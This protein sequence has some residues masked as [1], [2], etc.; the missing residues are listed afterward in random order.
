MGLKCQVCLSVPIFHYSWCNVQMYCYRLYWQ[1]TDG[2]FTLCSHFKVKILTGVVWYCSSPHTSW[3]LWCYN[4]H[5]ICSRTFG[6]GNHS[7][8]TSG[9]YHRTL[10]SDMFY[11]PENDRKKKAYMYFFSSDAFFFKVQGHSNCFRYS[12]NYVLLRER[13]LKPPPVA[14]LQWGRWSQ[15]SNPSVIFYCYRNGQKALHE[16][17]TKKAM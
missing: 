17:T 13:G 5:G 9:I 8:E 6:N 12:Q 1:V 11:E 7:A 14:L 4:A 10:V 15:Y 3:A 2:L 16:G